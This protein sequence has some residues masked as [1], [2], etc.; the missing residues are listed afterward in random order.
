M[1]ERDRIYRDIFQHFWHP[2]RRA[3]VQ[4]KGSSHMDAALLLLPLVKFLGP[5]DPRWLSTLRAIEE[6]LVYLV[7]ADRTPPGSWR[8]SIGGGACEDI[9]CD[10]YFFGELSRGFTPWLTSSIGVDRLDSGTSVPVRA[11]GSVGVSP[12]RRIELLWLRNCPAR[13]SRGRGVGDARRPR[14]KQKAPAG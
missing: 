3:F 13:W 4:Y 8:Y 9:G 10:S 5:T 12:A 2:G 7:P 6:E 11:F 1:E 14:T